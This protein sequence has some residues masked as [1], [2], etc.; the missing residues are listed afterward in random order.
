MGVCVPIA[1]KSQVKRGTP[2]IKIFK[3][4]AIRSIKLIGL[5]IMHNSISGPIKF[6]D[7]ANLRIPG[8]LQRFGVCYFVCASLVLVSMTVNF[9]KPE[10]VSFFF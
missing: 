7:D 5:G 9:T 2:R 1:I 10:G 3:S 6:G 4:I 8:V